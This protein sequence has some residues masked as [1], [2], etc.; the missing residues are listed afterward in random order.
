MLFSIIIPTYNR[1]FFLPNA[2]GSIINQKY[3][4]WELIIIDDGS[5][6]NTKE[7][8]KPYLKDERISYFY[9]KQ[10]KK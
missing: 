4:N 5:T 2:I 3:T 10:R 6:D 7:V 1:A 8:V 9:Q